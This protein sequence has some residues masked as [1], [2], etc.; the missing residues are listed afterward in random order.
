[1]WASLSLGRFVEKLLYGMAGKDVLG[2]TI[3]AAIVLC[4]ALAASY[5]PARRAVRVDPMTALRH[6]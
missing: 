2:L 3:A 5:L 4:V 6:Q 1:V